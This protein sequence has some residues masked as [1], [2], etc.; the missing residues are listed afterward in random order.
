MRGRGTTDAVLN[1]IKAP[2]PGARVALLPA[3]RAI[4]SWN[5]AAPAATL[6]LRVYAQDGRR[7]RALPYAV[8]E[9]G[10][11]ASLDG[12]DTLA[13]IETDVVHGETEIVA[14]EVHANAPLARVAVSTPP[15][16][17]PR[18]VA[19]A[20][21]AQRELAVPALSQYVDARPDERGWC[22]PAS[23]AMLLATWN[24][25]ASVAE[26]AAG[27]YDRAHGGTGNWAFAVAYAGAHG[28][29]GAVAYLRDLASLEGFIAAGLPPAVSI[30]WEDGDLPGA[31]LARSPGHVLVVQT[32]TRSSTIPPNRR[33]GTSIRARPSRAAGS[34]TGASHS[35]SLRRI[36]SMRFSR[37][38]THDATQ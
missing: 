27:I 24:V 19:C 30:A 13:R 38:R 25:T 28:L 21:A 37:A 12:F 22:V 31:P 3:R 1:L 20:A 35:S 14:V 10:T 16:A 7:S 9:P 34:G 8:F 18:D 4:V 11:R 26:V 36:V 32:G 15:D 5:T 2:G 6:E 23:I 33:C 29:V 17:A